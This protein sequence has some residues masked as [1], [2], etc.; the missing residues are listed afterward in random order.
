MRD[1]EGAKE[2]FRD[3]IDTR[4]YFDSISAEV[5]KNKI[6]E[7]IKEKNAPL[8]FVIADPGE[9]KS[10]IL[11]LTN[12]EIKN[13]HLTIFIDHPFF[14][15]RDLLKML[16]NAKGKFFDP[17]I[18]FNTLKE[19]IVKEYKDTNHTIFLDEAQLL[20]DEQ[21]ELVRILSDTKVFQFVLSMHKEE[22]LA[23]LEKKHFKSRTKVIVYLRSLTSNE[24]KR[25]IDSTL[26]LNG[27]GD[28]SQMF[29]DSHIK[30][31]AKYTNGNFRMIKKYLYSL[32][33]LLTYAKKTGL[34][35]YQK[36]N[37]CLL[38]MSALD[39]GLIDDKQ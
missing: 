27:Y 7:A 12:E 5:G 23:I 8:I 35:K 25:Y 17:S 19:E 16:Y 26:L 3:V 24:I 10:Y 15:K 38:D 32:F 31:I 18:N 37:R 22:G 1:F 21:F 29:K 9:G 13:E 20:N 2:L 4:Q 28:I 34:V 33:G 6:L 36:L 30:L 14:D 11:R 39:I